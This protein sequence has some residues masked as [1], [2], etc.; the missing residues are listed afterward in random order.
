LKKSAVVSGNASSLGKKIKLDKSAT[1]NGVC[2]TNGGKIT[3]AKAA[4]CIGGT[5]TSGTMVTS[6]Q[7]F[8]SLGATA[9][10]PASTNL[11]DLDLEKNGTA[12]LTANSTGVTIF[13][14]TSMNLGK[15]AKIT[16]TIPAGGL[17]VINDS[18]PLTMSDHAEISSPGANTGNLLVVTDSAKLD[19]NAFLD[20]TLV[21]QETCSLGSSADVGG[22]LYCAGNITL[23]SAFVGGGLLNEAIATAVT[24]TIS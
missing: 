9:C 2:A 15:S 16:V 23:G 17:V 8:S 11:G 24:C 7:N 5:D 13:D 14:Y 18:G 22:Q 21:A 12:M 19:S 3:L 10:P 4:S 6:L 20:G 1:V